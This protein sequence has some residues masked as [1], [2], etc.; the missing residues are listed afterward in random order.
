MNKIE[1]VKKVEKRLGITLKAEQYKAV[2][3]VQDGKDTF[4]IAAP[5]YGK[6]AV[7]HAAAL[8][9]ESKL[10]LVIEPTIS[11]IMAQ[12]NRLSSLKE[13]VRV[14]Y[15]TSHN[16][17]EHKDILKKV[18][19]RDVTVLYITPERLQQDSFRDAIR[20]NEPWL[21]V[22][23]ECHLVLS[24]GGSFRPD[25]LKIGQFVDGLKYK[26]VLLAMTA[27]AP[28]SY[29]KEIQESLHM[30]KPKQII[31]SIDKPNLSIIVDNTF[32]HKKDKP[33]LHILHLLKRLHHHI[34]T[35]ALDTDG[36]PR[37]TIIYCLTPDDVEVTANY[38]REIYA[39][40]VVVSHGKLPKQT[41]SIN[42][43]RFLSGEKKIMVATSA[44]GQGVDKSDIRLI[45]HYGLPLNIVDYYQQ[46]GRA[47]R[48]GAKAKAVVIYDKF[49]M[50]KNQGLIQSNH[51]PVVKRMKKEQKKL[52]SIIMGE[53]C[54]MQQLLKALGE[55]RETPC[56]HCTV[57]QRRRKK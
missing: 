3:A 14:A 16:K 6:S 26:P 28:T 52:E 18:K 42:E 41:R 10:V 37:S 17:D 47:G 57:C 29:R 38:F 12:V 40:D 32:H 43:L 27:T 44:F 35:H 9:D 25:Y 5:S 19:Y 8:L 56:N 53:K 11:L 51:E 13:P 33:K 48:D 31:L 55:K 4:M 49:L 46:I 21:V 39:G 7:F 30:N 22:V 1:S 34:K 23:D 36:N 24:W 45:I 2:Q 50:K 15:M 54:I 20:Q